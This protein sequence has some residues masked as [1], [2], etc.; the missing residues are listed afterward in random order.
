LNIQ[1]LT[2]KKRQTRCMKESQLGTGIFASVT[3]SLPWEDKLHQK[4]NSASQKCLL[5]N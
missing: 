3:K 4:T 1:H 2:W 5:S